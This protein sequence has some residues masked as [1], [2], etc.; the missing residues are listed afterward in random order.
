MC[1][2][3]RPAQ[4]DR[5]RPAGAVRPALVPRRRA[6]AGVAANGFGRTRSAAPR[7]L[8]PRQGHLA[9]AAAG[10]G[11]ARGECG[12]CPILCYPETRASLLCACSCRGRQPATSSCSCI[13]LTLPGS[14]LAHLDVFPRADGRSQG[15]RQGQKQGQRQGMEWSR[16]GGVGG[17]YTFSYT[18]RTM[19]YVIGIWT[20]IRYSTY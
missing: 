2:G 3:L 11:P 5:G 16:G 4:P 18:T 6:C 14:L 9:A 13:D 12:P 8:R 10:V 15:Q 17:G 1:A 7:H 20:F 19:H